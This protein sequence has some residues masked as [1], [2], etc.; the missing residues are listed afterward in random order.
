PVLGVGELLVERRADAV[1]DPAV[2]HAVHDVRIDHHA[3]VV[4]AH[5]FPD[6]GLARVR[7]DLDQNDVRL[8]GV[9]G[10]DL[11]TTLGSRQPGAGR[12][13]PDELRLQARLDARG[14]LVE[15]AVCDLDELVPDQPFLR[16]AL[17]AHAPVPLFAVPGRAFEL[18]RGGGGDR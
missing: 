17:H 12:H 10:V 8:E 6:R 5:V 7:V 3:A 1:R 14:Q 11:Y 18:V 15:L 16:F 13:F 2:G 4:P 9:A